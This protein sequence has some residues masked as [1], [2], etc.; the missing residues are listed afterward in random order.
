MQETVNI[1]G[2]RLLSIERLACKVSSWL[3][4][5]NLAFEMAPTIPRLIRVPKL[6]AK[7]MWFMMS[8]CFPLWESEIFVC[9]KV[10]AYELS[11]IKT[12]DYWAQV[13]LPR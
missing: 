7:T 13:S 3:A 8:P 1:A 11:L 9:V 12:L 4:S 2:L 10:G 6:R 5:G